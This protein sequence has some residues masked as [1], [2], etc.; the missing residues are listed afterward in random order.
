MKS[1]GQAAQGAKLGE[2]QEKLLAWEG[3]ACVCVC[4]LNAKCQ[5]GQG[6][7]IEVSEPR[8]ARSLSWRHINLQP[9]KD[10]E[11]SKDI[12]TLGTRTRSTVTCYGWFQRA[13]LG[14]GLQREVGGRL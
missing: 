4:V 14:W 13:W 11:L 5:S 7:T 6:G 3:C 9:I 8:D 1:G 2:K 12:S 10:Q